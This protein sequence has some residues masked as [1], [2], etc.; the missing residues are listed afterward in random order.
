M[1]YIFMEKSQK[2]KIF[3]ALFYLVL[4]S[5]F[6]IIFFSKYSYEE[7]S[8]YKFIQQNRDYFFFLKETNLI[9]ISFVFFILTIIW[10]FFAGFGSPIGLC[11]GFFFG[12]FLGAFIATIGLTFGA[13][14]LYIFGNY[15]LKDF[16]REKFLFK[17]KNLELKFKKNEFNYFLLYRFIGGVPFVVG[18]LLPVIFN[19]SIKNYFIGTFLGII[20]QIFLLASLGSGLE[21]VIQKNETAPSIIDLLFAPEIYIPLSAFFFIVLITIIIRKFFYKK[22]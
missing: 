17:F 21:K 16:I 13:T 1:I 5:S 12:N 9:L 11:A 6:L 8:S 15:F 18:N 7:I 14:F 10:V 3:L 22:K 19:I 2:F 4:L 20:P